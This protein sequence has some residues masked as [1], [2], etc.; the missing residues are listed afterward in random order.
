MSDMKERRIPFTDELF[1]EVERLAQ[2]EG[3]AFKY[4]AAQLIREAVEARA[5]AA[6]HERA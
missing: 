2:E 3:R 4:Q 6:A 1:D 5:K